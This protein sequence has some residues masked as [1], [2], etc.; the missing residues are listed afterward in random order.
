MISLIKQFEVND[1]TASPHQETAAPASGKAR[2][3]ARRRFRGVLKSRDI[4]RLLI[5]LLHPFPITTKS[6]PL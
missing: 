5:L 2:M 3:Q 1:R 4:C 6:L